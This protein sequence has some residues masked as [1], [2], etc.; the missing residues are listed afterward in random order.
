MTRIKVVGWDADRVLYPGLST[1]ICAKSSELDPSPF[2]EEFIQ[3]G[4]FSPNDVERWVQEYNEG[5]YF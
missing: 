4:W 3:K 1:S 2:V 5:K